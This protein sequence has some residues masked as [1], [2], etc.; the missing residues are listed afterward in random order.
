MCHFIIL[1]RELLS[2]RSGGGRLNKEEKM[3]KKGECE[4]IAWQIEGDSH[5]LFFYVNIWGSEFQG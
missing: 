3:A 5:L 1:Q 2:P 4:R